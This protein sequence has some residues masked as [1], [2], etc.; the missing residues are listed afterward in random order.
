M[1][2]AMTTAEL[3]LIAMLIIFSVPYLIWRLFRT[4]HYAGLSG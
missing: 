2:H 3:F 4:E 1:N